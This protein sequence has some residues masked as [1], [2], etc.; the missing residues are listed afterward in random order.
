[1]KTYRYTRVSIKYFTAEIR[2]KY[3]ID[4]VAQDGYIYIEIRNGMYGLKEAGI[5]ASNAL[6]KI[7]VPFGYSPVKLTPVLW[8][9]TSIT[10]MFTLVVD[11]FGIKYTHT[12]DVE[13]LF[14]ALCTSY[15]I[16]T[17]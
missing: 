10:I 11:D 1:M 17:D 7:L 15:D 9:H 12:Q 5:I 6:V 4:N 13:N 3:N 16:Y 14:R 8:K 2:H